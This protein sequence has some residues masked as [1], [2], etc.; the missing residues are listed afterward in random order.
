MFEQKLC[1]VILLFRRKKSIINWAE[2]KLVLSSVILKS[3]LIS[4]D[5]RLFW[6]EKFFK[7]PKNSQVLESIFKHLIFLLEGKNLYQDT[8]SK[9]KILLQRKHREMI[10]RINFSKLAYKL[11]VGDREN[12]WSSNILVFDF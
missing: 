11:M 7:S 5:L 1:K 2:K 6:L 3:L 9:L 4:S 10:I 8:S 12:Y